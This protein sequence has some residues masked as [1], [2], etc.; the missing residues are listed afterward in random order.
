MR[1]LTLSIKCKVSF[2]SVSDR[3][4]HSVKLCSHN[5]TEMRPNLIIWDLII[6]V[7]KKYNASLCV[8]LFAYNLITTGP[9]YMIVFSIEKPRGT[10]HYKY[11][12]IFWILLHMYCNMFI[13]V[14]V[15]NLLLYVQAYQVRRVGRQ[16]W[17]P[18]LHCHDSNT[19]N[20]CFWYTD[21]GATTDLPGWYYTSFWKML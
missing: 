5:L 11:T 3:I 16:W 17:L 6:Y 12:H 10:D 15:Y 4:I 8:C 7:Y 9:I 13:I 20:D 2:Q 18:I 21:I 1:F 14:Y 19:S